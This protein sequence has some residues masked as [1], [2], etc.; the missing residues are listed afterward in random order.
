M[1]NDKLIKYVILVYIVFSGIIAT[2]FAIDYFVTGMSSLAPSYAISLAGINT[3]GQIASANLTPAQQ[4]NYINMLENFYT[5]GSI[6]ERQ[7]L[8]NLSL[9]QFMGYESLFI[10]PP[11]ILLGLIYYSFKKENND[12]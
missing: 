8:A 12:E 6:T 11:F 2:A 5:I 4:S 9:S 10:I 7:S 1:M 3:L